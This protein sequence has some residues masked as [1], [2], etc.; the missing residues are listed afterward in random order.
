MW[1]VLI[2]FAVMD[3][4]CYVHAKLQRYFTFSEFLSVI[5]YKLHSEEAHNL[6]S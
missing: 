2:I 4:K 5:I 1:M 6:D 3:L